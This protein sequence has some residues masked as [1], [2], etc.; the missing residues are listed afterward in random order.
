MR[1]KY[2]RFS[3]IEKMISD[4]EKVKAIRL[5]MLDK[6]KYDIEDIEKTITSLKNGRK[7]RCGYPA[8]KFPMG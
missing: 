3:T 6:L 5:K 4:L 2:E 1:K 7:Y 8:L